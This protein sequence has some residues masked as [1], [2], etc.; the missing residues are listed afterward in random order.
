MFPRLTGRRLP[1]LL[2][3]LA[4]VVLTLGLAA[5]GDDDDDNGNARP[6]ATQTRASADSNPTQPP[7]TPDESSGGL[8]YAKL[9]GQIRIDGSSTVF[10]ISEAMAEEFGQ[11]SNVRVNVA[12]SGTGGGFEKFCRGETQIS[13]A[14]RPIK[15]SEREE[16]AKIGI[17]DVVEIQ[18]AIDALTV[19]VNPSNDWAQC[20]TVEEVHNA[21]KDGG[22]RTWSDIR[23]GWPDQQITFFYPGT[24]SGTFDYFNEAIIL[25]V[26]K[27]ANHRSDGTASEDDNVLVIGIEGDKN[28]LG[29]F[30]FAYFVGAG[31]GLKAVDIDG[32]E[33]CV[34]PTFENA[35][36]GAY[37]PLARPL[38]IYTREVFL[39]E[40]PEVL[41][42]LKFYIENLDQIVP[43]VGYVSM[44]EELT[45]QQYAKI[46]PFLP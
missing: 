45:Q 38:F 34:E 41:G 24:D 10:P 7:K 8:D 4:L 14:S 21:F 44:P 28:A 29:Y 27:E 23:A 3:L 16:C 35:V 15:S 6:T 25:G 17:D 31:S 2:W 18:V 30:G 12:F 46:E 32:G 13:N 9:S 33:G 11:V 20:M 43:E 1:G 22:A 5:C 19:V 39:Q 36:S 42:F 26:N 37:K 40:R